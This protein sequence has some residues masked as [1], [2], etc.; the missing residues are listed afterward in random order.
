MK[1]GSNA[2][3]QHDVFDQCLEA[4]KKKVGVP[5]VPPVEQ[6]QQNEQ[7]RLAYVAATKVWRANLARC[8]SYGEFC[9]VLAQVPA[10]PTLPDWLKRSWQMDDTL[11]DAPDSVKLYTQALDRNRELPQR[12]DWRQLS[13]DLCADAFGPRYMTCDVDQIIKRDVLD[14]TTS[15]ILAGGVGVGK[16][17]SMVYH[18]LRLAEAMAMDPRNK[19]N[20]PL[21]SCYK[22]GHLFDV[23]FDV[24]APVPHAAMW[25][26]YL[27]LDDVGREYSTQ[28]P[29]HR[30]EELVE[31]RYSRGLGFIITTNMDKQT[32]HDREGWD[33]I[34]DRLLQIC[35]W[36]DVPGASKRQ[37]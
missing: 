12:A 15:V 9:Q 22:S 10:E 26:Q 28:W 4:L 25:A 23:L 30:F 24:D 33:R 37:A 17:T 27:V 14:K 7:H 3:M 34:T 5:N 13:A 18:V 1:G 35:S 8:D 20:I 6:E 16:T 36:I 31:E 2:T 19:W 21:F 29:L 11:V 32:F